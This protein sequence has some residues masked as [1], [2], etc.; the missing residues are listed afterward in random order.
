MSDD[1]FIQSYGDLEVIFEP[2]DHTY[3][4]ALGSDSPLKVP[5]VSEICDYLPKYGLPKWYEKEA[6]KGMQ[7][8]LRRAVRNGPSG[9]W[10]GDV[11]PVDVTRVGIDDPD[12]TRNLIHEM[13]MGGEAIKNRKAD[14]GTIV[15]SEFRGWAV[16]RIS[17]SPENHS[18]ETAG[19][20]KS[21]RMF[22]DDIGDALEV[23][24]CEAPLASASYGFAGTPDLFCRFTKPVKL[25]TGGNQGP[26]KRPKFETFPAGS[27]PLIDLKT[28][29]QVFL[30]HSY[31]LSAYELMLDECGVGE[32][33]DRWI[34]LIKPDGAGYN[35]KP[36]QS[37]TLGFLGCLAVYES[38]KRPGGWQGRRIAPVQIAVAA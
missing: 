34:V 14:I 7:E 22:T 29:A 8:L 36:Q 21:L 25:Q 27:S 18:G 9:D 38:E 6:I 20:V 28:S 17:P 4:L 2:E 32:P 35:V 16:N 31:Q 5:P 13:G 37:R 33:S 15:H 30:S 1:K 23:I 11:V 10:S 19:Y 3:H 26:G 12:F 24:L